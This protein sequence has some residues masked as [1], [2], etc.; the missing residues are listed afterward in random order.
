MRRCPRSATKLTNYE[1]DSIA[2]FVS[3]WCWTHNNLANC[4]RLRSSAYVELH[5]GS[6][7]PRCCAQPYVRRWIREHLVNGTALMFFLESG[8]LEFEHKLI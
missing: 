4:R 6:R 3:V 5:V 7:T 8:M 1:M 2:G